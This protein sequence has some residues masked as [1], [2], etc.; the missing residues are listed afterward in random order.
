VIVALQQ[1]FAH[2]ENYVFRRDAIRDT[3]TVADQSTD[4]RLLSIR[5]HKYSALIRIREEQ[6]FLTEKLRESLLQTLYPL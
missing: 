6:L 2:P 3:Q 1:R 5:F 4:Y